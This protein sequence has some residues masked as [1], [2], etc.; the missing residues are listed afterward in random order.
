MLCI[1]VIHFDFKIKWLTFNP[2]IPFHPILS[3]GPMQAYF[4]KNGCQYSILSSPTPNPFPYST[5][6]SLSHVINFKCHYH[7][8]SSH[9]LFIC[10]LFFVFYLFIL[11]L[12]F[13]INFISICSLCFYFRYFKARN[14]SEIYC[15]IDHF[16]KQWAYFTIRGKNSNNIDLHNVPVL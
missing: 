12:F 7:S 9:V 10:S 2:K 3:I 1:S 13:K 6:F 4:I 15:S 16:L 14:N 5:L 11:L 8:A